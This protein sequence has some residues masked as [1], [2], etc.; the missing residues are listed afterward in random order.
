MGRLIQDLELSYRPV[1]LRSMID[2]A[3]RSRKPIGRKNI[4]FRNHGRESQY[5]DISITPFQREG[6]L[7]ATTITFSDVTHHH[8]LQENLQR[9]SENLETAY[10]ELQSANEELETTN[11]EL[12]SANEELETT[13][14]ELQAANE[15]ME[16]VNEELRSTN[17]ELQSANE[18]LRKH[19]EE[20]NRSNAFLHS[21]LFSMRSGLAVVG[22][23]LAVKMWNELAVDLWGVRADEVVGRSFSELD[24]GLPVADLIAPLR[25]VMAQPVDELRP[26]ELLVAA[27]NRRGRDFWCRVVL[28]RM[29]AKSGIL[30]GACILMED[31]TARL[32]PPSTGGS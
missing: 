22:Q 23:D 16:T 14:E 19:E 31:V 29:N 6:V 11:E 1:D 18:R 9:F 3:H 2:E 32:E 21:I 20:L 30:D 4:E 28:S 25:E 12:Q 8:K 10:E 7:L 26:R 24:I 15:E 17:E 5:L 13:N 27:V